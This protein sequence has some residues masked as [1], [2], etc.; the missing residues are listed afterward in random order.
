LSK[1]AFKTYIKKEWTIV[2][3]GTIGRK[4]RAKEKKEKEGVSELL[5]NKTEKKKTKT[6]KK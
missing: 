1:S 3:D 6:A 5:V 2:K 4:R